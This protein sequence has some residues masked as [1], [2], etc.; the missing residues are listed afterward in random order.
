M[1]LSFPKQNGWTDR[2]ACAARAHTTVLD[3]GFRGC[4]AS[5]TCNCIFQYPLKDV[6]QKVQ[7]W[8]PIG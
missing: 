6:V 8:S 1:V 3:I 7:K 2:V 4:S 5:Y